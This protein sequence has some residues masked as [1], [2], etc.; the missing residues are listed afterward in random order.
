[1]FH[2]DIASNYLSEKRIAPKKPYHHGNLKNALIEKS[3][4]IIKEEGIA[5]LSLRKAARKAG[6]SHA[7]P[8]HHFG[9]LTGLLASI[10]QKGFELLLEEIDQKLQENIHQSPLIRLKSIGL[11]YISF[12]LNHSYY[13]KVMFCSKLAEQSLTQDLKDEGRKICRR[14]AQCVQDCQ[15]NQLIRNEDPM[16]MAAFIWTSIHGYATLTVNGKMGID[17]LQ[18]IDE[19]L[20]EMVVNTVCLGLQN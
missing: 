5:A 7:A 1:M 16:K 9:D 10:A 8:A 14:L 3:I 19:H 11:S 15:R 20:A 17:E 13:F 18:T 4:D 12:A 6:V 2:A